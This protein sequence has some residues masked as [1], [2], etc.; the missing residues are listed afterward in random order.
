MASH[1]APSG[2]SYISKIREKFEED[3][4]P[5]DVEKAI[6][7]MSDEEQEKALE[8][9]ESFMQHAPLSEQR[10]ARRRWINEVLDRFEKQR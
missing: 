9:L 7:S 4:F 5:L 6:E 1:E 3:R 8:R 2:E 10:R